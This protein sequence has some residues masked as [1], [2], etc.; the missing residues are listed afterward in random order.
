MSLLAAMTWMK[1]HT[2]SK[3]KDQREGLLYKLNLRKGKGRKEGKGKDLCL[4]SIPNQGHLILSDCLCSLGWKLLKGS[5]L[6][7]SREEKE[8]RN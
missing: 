3:P 1:D 8:V 6:I 5:C 7:N 4:Y 2:K